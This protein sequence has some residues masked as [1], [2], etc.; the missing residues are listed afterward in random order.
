M[1]FLF[2]LN[3]V[4]SVFLTDLL[5]PISQIFPDPE[6][7]KAIMGSMV[8]CIHHK[9]GCKWTDELR[10]LK[11]HLNTCRHDAIPCT[12][13]CGA[14][15]PRVLMDDHLRHTCPKRRARCESCGREFTGELLEA[16]TVA[17]C[18][19]EPI[20]CEGK[21]GIK[22]ARRLLA[23]HRATECPKRLVPCRHCGKEFVADTMQAHHSK[24][25]RFPLPCPNRCYV[26]G[27]GGVTV[28]LIPREELETH[29]K[30]RCTSVSVCCAF[31]DAG[32]RFKGPRHAVE[33]HLEEG[34]K[35]HLLLMCGVVSKQQHQIS[36]LKGALGRLSLNHTGTL[37]WRVTDF[38]A[39]MA[40]AKTKEGMELVSAPF[41]TSQYGYKLQASLF[42]NG[43][44]AGDGTHMSVYIKI[45]P[46][47]YDALLRW[48]FA[49]SVS[50]T[51]FD[52]TSVPEKA[53]SIVESF[54]PDPTWKN[55]QRPSREPDS[56]GFGFPRFVPHETLKRRHYVKDDTLFLRVKVDP[57]KI[58]AV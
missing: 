50:F 17:G 2:I 49:H 56:L 7:E 4:L 31:K 35:Q 12:R 40:E 44:G 41:Y 9:D 58:V 52:Q 29:L 43:N 26:D 32:C 10:K 24:C 45:L 25:G 47:E 51:L 1:C 38:A 34:T 5:L 19:S 8:Y 13:Q 21:C 42:L 33:K 18:P 16:H 39:K 36:S 22:V 48:P 15:I 53:C 46:G 20:Y 3:N 54:I 11:A 14:Q 37:I 55:F 30:D 28:A 57:S 23:Q 27:T 6:A